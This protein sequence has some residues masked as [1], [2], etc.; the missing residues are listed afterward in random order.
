MSYSLVSLFSGAGFLDFGFTENDFKVIWGAE[1]IPYFAESNNYN[2]QLRYG[3]TNNP[4]QTVDITTVDPADIPRTTGIIGGPPCQDYSIANSKSP[5]VSG[6]RG[7]LVW[8]FMDKISHLSPEFFIFENVAALYRTKKHRKEALEPLIYQFNELGYEV[9]FKVLNTLDYG[10]PQDRSR[11]FIVGFKKHII[12][13]LNDSGLDAFQWP[14]QIYENP[15]K[16]F[17]WPTTNEAAFLDECEYIKQMNVPY[18]LTIHSVIGNESEIS[19]LRNHVYFTPYSERFQTVA[20]GDVKRKSFKRLHRF[21]YSP[22]VAYGNNEVH[23]HPTL[24]RRLSVREALRLQSV[25]DW[26]TFKDTTPLDKMFKMVSNGVA[27]KLSELLAIQVKSVLD[28]Y[29]SLVAKKPE[30][31]SVH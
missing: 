24:P 12:Q 4:I 15:K 16:D 11:V 17:E 13:T 29:H 14:T 3:L 27:F 30:K 22:T 5:G 6:E 1:L 25:P 23:L 20:E 7:K 10:I 9:Y 19:K 18:E 2:H 8:D 28:N 31:I 26:Y 21:R